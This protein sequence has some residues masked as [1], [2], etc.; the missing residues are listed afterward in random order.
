MLDKSGGGSAQLNPHYRITPL[1][2]MIQRIGQDRIEFAKGCA[3]HR[4]E[5]VIE[6]E[7]HAE[8]FDN[9]DLH[10]PA[11]PAMQSMDQWFS[12]M[13]RWPRAS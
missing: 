10:G 9:E 8:Y 3:N 5:P 13:K 11:V 2:G 7:F 1:D 4:W 6:G 12:G